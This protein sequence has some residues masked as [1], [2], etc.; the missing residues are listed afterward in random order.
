MIYLTEPEAV[1]MSYPPHAALQK[2]QR[3]QFAWKS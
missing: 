2:C 3:Q 1:T